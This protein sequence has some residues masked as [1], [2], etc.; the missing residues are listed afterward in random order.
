MCGTLVVKKCKESLTMPILALLSYMI[1]SHHI[2]GTH[3]FTPFFLNRYRYTHQL[4]LS[5]RATYL[6]LFNLTES[7]ESSLEEIRFWASSIL[8]RCKQAKVVLVGT[9]LDKTDNATACDIITRLSVSLKASFPS[10]RQIGCVV[11]STGATSS[12]SSSTTTSSSSSSSLP[13]SRSNGSGIDALKKILVSDAVE[14]MLEVPMAIYSAK[15]VILEV[16][17]LQDERDLPPVLVRRKLAQIISQRVGIT[18]PD[19]LEVILDALEA[20]GNIFTFKSYTFNLSLAEL[21]QHRIEMSERALAKKSSAARSSKSATSGNDANYPSSST[22]ASSPSYSSPQLDEMGGSTLSRRKSG[23]G[24]SVKGSDTERKK[25]GTSTSQTLQLRSV[26]NERKVREFAEN[27][28]GE[29]VNVL[30]KAAE[31]QL[32]R[33]MKEKEEYRRSVADI[34]EGDAFVVVRPQWLTNLLSSIVNTHQTFVKRGVLQHRDLRHIWM[35]E[36]QFPP[37]LHLHMYDLLRTL[38]VLVPMQGEEGKKFSERSSFVPCMLDEVAP[39]DH[40]EWISKNNGARTMNMNGRSICTSAYYTWHRLY[41]LRGGGMPVGVMPRLLIFILLECKGDQF[42]AWSDGCNARIGDFN[43]R[44]EKGFEAG[45]GVECVNVTLIGRCH[46]EG[47][48]RAAYVLR[49]LHIVMENLFNDLYSLFYEVR[50][51]DCWSSE[52]YS[53]AALSGMAAKGNATLPNGIRLDLLCPDLA[54]LDLESGEGRSF[55]ISEKELDYGAEREKLGEGGFA[56]VWKA[57]LLQRRCSNGGVEG[58]VVD[59]AVKELR[60]SSGIGTMAIAGVMSDFHHEAWLMSCLR[61]PNVVR[62]LGVTLHPR[63]AM[64]MELV[65]GG[66]LFQQLSDPLSIEST[67]GTFWHLLSAAVSAHGMAMSI[68]KRMEASAPSL[69]PFRSAEADLWRKCGT[70]FAKKCRTDYEYEADDEGSAEY[71]RKVESCFQSWR[72]SSPSPELEALI[73]DFNV[74]LDAYY[75]RNAKDTHSS[76]ES[77]LE[78][79]M[80]RAK[81]DREKICPIDWN[82]RVKIAT[83]VARS[84]SFMHSLTPPVIH[85]DL[86][87]VN[88]MLAISL[89]DFRSLRHQSTYN[90]ADVWQN[91]LAKVT[92]FGLSA[93]LLGVTQ[94][95]V[96]RE[97][98]EDFFS[99]SSSSSGS[100]DGSANSGGSGNS[101]VSAMSN[102]ATTWAAPEILGGRPYTTRSD[103]YAMGLLLWE[104]IER[105]KPFHAEFGGSAIGGGG[106]PKSYI[107]EGGRPAVPLPRGFYSQPYLDLMQRCWDGEPENRPT[108][109]EI[110]NSLKEMSTKLAPAVSP[111]LAALPSTLVNSSSSSRK[112]KEG[113]DK[114]SIRQWNRGRVSNVM[115]EFS[116]LLPPSS[117]SSSSSP[118]SS[119]SISFAAVSTAESTPGAST[120]R[121]SCVCVVRDVDQCCWVGL[122][123]GM[124]AIVEDDGVAVVCRKND[125]HSQSIVGILYSSIDDLVWTGSVDGQL[126]VWAPQMLQA[127][128]IYEQVRLCGWMGVGKPG[129]R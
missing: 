105:E 92:D 99:G 116:L 5:G 4:F 72:Q 16:A 101:G 78:A 21:E 113:R 34:K 129:A 42:S 74:C 83:D 104:L 93:Q 102:I 31:A 30:T 71:W 69:P 120:M 1:G 32:K 79:L 82:T 127:Q 89:Q 109:C 128:N 61:H 6:L 37:E 97:S 94:L 114:K 3:L 10:A 8:L 35:D 86:K 126:K 80:Q 29:A 52:T 49:R 40:D 62:L 125:K 58:E 107:I 85:R 96:L 15:D 53:M 48:A 90:E 22:S 20:V 19:V 2:D 95:Q 111:S 46:S 100:R 56:I 57:K 73:E 55:V 28:A 39:M 91:P 64:V 63:P 119:S 14:D 88:V 25:R 50:I 108:M 43:V 81:Q 44:V 76:V 84:M 103:V 36:G 66:V 17:A 33:R 23:Q 118:L 87:S 106:P 7:V 11:L 24:S 65:Q 27:V 75:A 60:L 98:E 77:S 41:V 9:H 13:S 18:N 70:P 122:R 51:V 68:R 110:Y 12:S 47:A 112:E 117:P 38:E 123:N 67:L 115:K 26:E 59:V 121:V 124:V 45:E 54:F